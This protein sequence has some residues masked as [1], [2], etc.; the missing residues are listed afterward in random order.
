MN[1][2][3]LYMAPD[4]MVLEMMPRDGSLV[5]SSSTIQSLNGETDYDDWD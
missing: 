4:V 1:K 2:K 5:T 3:N